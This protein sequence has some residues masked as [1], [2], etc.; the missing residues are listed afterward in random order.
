MDRNTKKRIDSNCTTGESFGFLDVLRIIAG[1]LFANALLSWFF[2]SSTTWNCHG[3]WIDSSYLVFRLKNSYVNLTIDELAGYDGED[4]SKQ[5]Y[6]AINGSVYD[7]SAARPIYGPGGPYAKFAGK[8][9]ARA[10]ITGCLDKPDEFTYDLRGIDEQEAYETLQQW[11]DFY[12]KHS[13]YW[14]AGVVTH[15]DIT[16]PPPALC[17]HVKYPG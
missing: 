15:D 2:T 9:A 5:L 6:I 7:V 13:K 1:L 8:D 11:H 12:T 17:D 3:K 14:Y 16:G 4:G 10:W